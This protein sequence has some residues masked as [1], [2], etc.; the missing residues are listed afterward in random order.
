[1]KLKLIALLLC[2]SLTAACLSGCGS[3]APQVDVRESAAPTETAAPAETPAES[4]AETPEETPDPEEEARKARYQSAYE[5]YTPDQ[6]VMLVNGAPITWEK[7]Y[8]WIYDIAS[9]MEKNYGVTDWNAPREELTGVVPDSTFGS[10]VRRTALGC[11]VQL[12]VI[13]QKAEEMGIT[14][15]DEQRSELQATIDGY[16]SRFGGQEALEQLLADS[17]GTMDYFIEQNEA[18]FLIDN[19]YAELYG[20]KGADLPEADA[21]AYLK[22]NGYLYAK[23][24]LFSTVDDNRQPLPDEEAAAKK[25]EA[26]DVLRQLR[27]CP[28]EDLP[29][30]FDALMQQ[31]NEDPGM[32]SFPDGYYFLAGEMVPEFEEAVRSLEENG[33]SD[34]VKTDYGYHIIFCPP[35]GA[36][37]IMGYDSSYNAYTPKAFVSTALFDSVFRDWCTDAEKNV[38]YVAGFESFDLNELFRQ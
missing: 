17:Y 33:L 10:Y 35:M 21:V 18:T 26:E 32:L 8:S 5:K 11:T 38:Q 22:D 14:L 27:A 6:V 30:L 1:M 7:Y 34:L 19:I 31:Y 4:P 9:Q 29:T 3:E 37:D 28:A 16:I 13:R 36:D 15:S 20:V 12:E 24:I 23:H 2:L 25:A